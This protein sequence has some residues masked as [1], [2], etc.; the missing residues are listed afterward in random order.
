M[1]GMTTHHPSL[2]MLRKWMDGEA[3]VRVSRHL[4]TCERCI[5]IMDEESSLTE[6]A[7]I[8]LR[9]ITQPASDLGARM[10]YEV[11]EKIRNREVLGVV[12]DLFGLGWQ[13][14]SEWLR[15]EDDPA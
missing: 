7:R 5:A 9:A 12:G 4:D 6:E 13:T 8:A 1:E 3:P 11:D 15:P 10:R 14:A 2:R